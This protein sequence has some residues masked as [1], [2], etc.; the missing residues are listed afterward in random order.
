MRVVSRCGRA[1]EEPGGG[2]RSTGSSCGTE[3]PGCWVDGIRCCGTISNFRA[4]GSTAVGRDQLQLTVKRLC[5]TG[6]S[7]LRACRCETLRPARRSAR[8]RCPRWTCRGARAAEVEVMEAR[9]PTSTPRC[10]QGRG[11][12]SP[13]LRAGSLRMCHTQAARGPGDRSHADC[14]QIS[15]EVH[16]ARVSWTSGARYHL[17]A[18]TCQES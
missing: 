1:P 18:L 3:P 17:T 8:T 16:V 9:V 7:S 12:C 15:A 10:T 13:L 5:A 4:C 2:R 14:C 11:H 6:T